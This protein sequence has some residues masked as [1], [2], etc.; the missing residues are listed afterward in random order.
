MSADIKSI[1]INK[2]LGDN[3]AKYVFMEIELKKKI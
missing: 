2:K 3:K 1:P